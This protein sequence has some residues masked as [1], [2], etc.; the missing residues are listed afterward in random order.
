MSRE[1]NII[2]PLVKVKLLLSLAN[3]K[4]ESVC[5]YSN[6]SYILLQ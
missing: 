3:V 2:K 4:K 6:F 5:I 1:G